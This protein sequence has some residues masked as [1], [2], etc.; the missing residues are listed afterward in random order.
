VLEFLD[1][2]SNPAVSIE[3]FHCVSL[4]VKILDIARF[5]AFLYVIEFHWISLKNGQISGQKS[6]NPSS[7]N[8]SI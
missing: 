7:E 4:N 3:Q 6:S 2:G 5:L 8:D 1:A